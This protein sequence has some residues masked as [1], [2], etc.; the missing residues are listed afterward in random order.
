MFPGELIGEPIE[1]VEST[2]KSNIG[3]K[4]KIVDETKFT[5]KV[6][7]QGKIK[8]LFKSTLLFKLGKNGKI[9]N[10]K[11]MMKRPEERIKGN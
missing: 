6:S 11:N 9:I 5:I 10:G 2:N 4:G 8:T 7:N 1:V 3:L